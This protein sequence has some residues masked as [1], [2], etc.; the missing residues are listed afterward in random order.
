MKSMLLRSE[1]VLQDRRIEAQIGHQPLR[2]AILV[3]K[4]LQSSRLCHL[5]EPN[6]FFHLSNLGADM[7][8]LRQV[9]AIVCPVG[10]CASALA[11]CSSAKRLCITRTSK[12]A[13]DRAVPDNSLSTLLS[14]KGEDQ[15]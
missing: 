2:L 4:L 15:G 11:I 8:S 3:L 12:L 1:R 7:P 13:G 14:N 10:S 6:Y 5:I 9:F